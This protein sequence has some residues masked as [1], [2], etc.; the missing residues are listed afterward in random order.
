MQHIY[1]SYS[2]IIIYYVYIYI[3]SV[4]THVWMCLYTYIC[5]T[6]HIFVYNVLNIITFVR[7]IRVSTTEQISTYELYG[8]VEKWQP[9]R[10]DLEI[11][12]WFEFQYKGAD[13]LVLSVLP[14]YELLNFEWWKRAMWRMQNYILL[15]KFTARIYHSKILIFIT[16]VSNPF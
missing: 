15:L 14:C 4:C 10:A 12:L 11:R 16:R 5:I 7:C 8:S 9:C 3:C 2:N 13:F 6:L 1:R